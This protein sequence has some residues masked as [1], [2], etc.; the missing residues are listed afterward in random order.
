VVAAAKMAP[1]HAMTKSSASTKAMPSTS[2]MTTGTTALTCATPGFGAFDSAAL[3]S[4]TSAVVAYSVAV[5]CTPSAPKKWRGY[6]AIERA[7]H[8]ALLSDALFGL[9]LL[10]LREIVLVLKSELVAIRF[11]LASL[12]EALA[13]VGVVVPEDH[14]RSGLVLVQFEGWKML[15]VFRG[16]VDENLRK[17]SIL[18]LCFGVTNGRFIV[19]R[20]RTRAERAEHK[21]KQRKQRAKGP[22]F[23]PD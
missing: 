22:H 18:E 2:A 9:I 7:C 11:G 10:V 15:Q 23:H 14:A 8:E 13:I 4:P 5:P 3:I 21:S 17:P 16:C 1:A 6:R 12:K 20:S 19:G